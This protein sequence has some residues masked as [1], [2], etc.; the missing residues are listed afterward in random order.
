MRSDKTGYAPYL[1]VFL[2]ELEDKIEI[3]KV[4]ELLLDSVTNLRGIHPNAEEAM[5]ALNSAIFDIT[6]VFHF[7]FFC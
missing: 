2:R 6:Q 5:Q 4:Q 7:T 3:A 1:G